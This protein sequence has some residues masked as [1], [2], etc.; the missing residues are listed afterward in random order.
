M[1]VWNYVNNKTQTN[2]NAIEP[3]FVQLLL[4]III[5]PSKSEDLHVDISPNNI[6]FEELVYTGSLNQQVK[7]MWTPEA[8]SLFMINHPYLDSL[9]DVK[10]HNAL[11]N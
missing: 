6:M 3:K 2:A 5:F 9:N 1:H 11:K 4:I 8:L 7:L 10:I